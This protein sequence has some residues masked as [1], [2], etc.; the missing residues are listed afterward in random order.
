MPK[1]EVSNLFNNNKETKVK[2]IIHVTLPLRGERKCVCAFVTKYTLNANT[3][4]K[5]GVPIVAPL[6]FDPLPSRKQFANVD[7]AL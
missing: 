3:S 7:L 1:K 5:I 6:E 4:R 2:K